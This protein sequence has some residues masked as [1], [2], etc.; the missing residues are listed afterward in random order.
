MFEAPELAA[1]RELPSSHDRAWFVYLLPLTDCTAFKVGFSCNPLQRIYGFSRRYYERFDLHQALLL[2][3]GECEQARAIEA[4]L[5]ADL[6]AY[7]TDA[8]PWLPRAAGGYTE[9]FSAVHF[10]HAQAR[11]QAALPDQDSAQVLSA[12][13]QIHAELGRR[14]TDF[15]S[16]AWRLAQQVRDA[17][18]VYGTGRGSLRDWIDAYRFFGIP[19]FAD[20][21]AARQFV[22]AAR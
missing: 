1:G 17:R 15:E 14:C 18:A 16:W 10:V 9:W 22:L 21:P 11:L 4:L 13:D 20:D 2:R 7:R 6:A 19:V 3:L 8:P 5:K 12:F